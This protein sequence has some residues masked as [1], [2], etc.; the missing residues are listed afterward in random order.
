MSLYW[1]TRAPSSPSSISEEEESVP[2]AVTVSSFS[3]FTMDD[4]EHFLLDESLTSSP[5]RALP[6]LGGSQRSIFA[7]YWNSPSR[8]SNSRSNEEDDIVIQR[9]ASLRLPLT[10]GTGSAA[11]TLEMS[12]DGTKKVIGSVIAPTETVSIERPKKSNSA[13]DT[14][15]TYHAPSVPPKPYR[16]R[17]LPAPPRRQSCSSLIPQQQQLCHQI[18]GTRA[19]ERKWRSASELQ[20][21]SCLRSTGRYDS[22]QRLRSLSCVEP[23]G[24]TRKGLDRSVSFHGQVDV[25]EFVP[26]KEKPARNKEWR[27]YF[28]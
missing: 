25:Y 15:I 11:S 23:H 28:A 14:S 10:D 2:E 9:T 19:P 22:R 27:S 26:P 1:R 5:A 12:R 16:R 20:G 8:S 7:S 3:T 17:I 6:S 13:D 18:H 24:D 4:D 21:R